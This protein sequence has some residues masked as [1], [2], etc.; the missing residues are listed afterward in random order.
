M[1]T[2]IALFGLLGSGNIGNNGSFEAVVNFLHRD[3]PDAEL[4]CICPDPEEMT[5]QYGIPAH[6]IT[7][8]G[9]RPSRLRLPLPLVAA[10]KAIGKGVDAIRTLL[11]VR[12]VDVV[13]IPGMG[14]LETTLPLRPWG[15]PYALFLTAFWSRITGARLALVSV[16]ANV[17]LQPITRRLIVAT[18]GLAHYRSYRD[19]QAREAMTQMGVDT[20][21]DEVYP[22]LAFALPAPL[23]S[24][25][26]LPPPDALAARI[27]G[28][29]VM[30]YSG[31]TLD[32]HRAEEISSNYVNNIVAFVRAL[33]DTGYRVRLFTGDP[34]DVRVVNIIRDRIADDKVTFTP[35]SSLTELMA[36]MEDVAVVVASRFH[37]LVSAIKAG[38]PTISLSYA[39]KSDMLMAGLGLGEFCQSIRSVDVERLLKQVRELER[40]K[41]SIS[42][43]LRR[44]CV[45]YEALVEQ[46]FVALT[47]AVLPKRSHA[48]DASRRLSG[49]D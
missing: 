42:A 30:D 6:S 2:R 1:A 10:L 19:P 14:V 18:A 31:T 3:H 11:W 28:L 47:A 21:R 34:T 40:R 32:R 46:Q 43:K 48:R 49:A 38:K 37:N 44:A 24:S 35:A 16:G 4:I 33:L 8:Y 7:W 27:V 20:F 41:D 25:L 29:G 36:Q 23:P 45:P 26:T 13:I 39:S 9:G 12:K 22:D 5:R 15:V 17:I